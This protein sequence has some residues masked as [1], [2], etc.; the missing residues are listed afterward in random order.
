MN[1]RTLLSL[2]GGVAV[3]YV[4]GAAAGRARY[5]QL[6]QG[7]TDVLQ[8]PRVQQAV[9]DLAGQAKANAHRIPGPASRLVD[10]ASTR[11]QDTLTQPSDVSSV[12]P[13]TFEV[14]S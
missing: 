5:E 1:I 14:G 2:S 11:V 12:D 4:L 8:H 13:V 3:G 10:T 7:A 6:K 9:F